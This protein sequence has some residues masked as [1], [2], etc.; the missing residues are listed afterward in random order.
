MATIVTRA[1]KGSTLTHAEM[2]ANFNN[3]N[4]DKADSPNST[5][6]NAI[7]RYDG[8]TGDLQNSGV[9]IEDDGTLK[10]GGVNNS[11]SFN[12]YF[13]ARNAL[14]AGYSGTSEAQ[15]YLHRD[16]LT[17]SADNVIGELN[18]S[19]ADSGSY[20][21]ASVK[22]VAAGSWGSTSTPANLV[23]QTTPAGST[24]PA[25]RMRIDAN[26]D[27]KFNSGY[28]SVATA[29]GVRAWANFDGANASIR[30]SGNVS[31]VTTTATGK[32]QINFTNAM[33]DVKYAVFASSQVSSSSS[34]NYS[35]GYTVPLATTSVTI[36]TEDSNGGAY[37]LQDLSVSIIR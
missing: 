17:I 21:G 25:E 19:G 28:G 32:H 10:A 31:S 36:E 3:L 24:T 7:A 26:G 23:F 37:S 34:K 8:T 2:D 11:V 20:V 29:Y 12:R 9:V 14:I 1:G 5:T 13:E 16:D 18:F 6:D 35:T 33:P 4:N 22:G 30:A 15:L 27:L